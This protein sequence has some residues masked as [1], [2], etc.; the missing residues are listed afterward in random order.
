MRAERLGV[1]VDNL[2]VLSE[3]NTMQILG[4]LSED[5]YKRQILS[6]L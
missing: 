2:F 4:A 5:V 1:N 3:T 6:K